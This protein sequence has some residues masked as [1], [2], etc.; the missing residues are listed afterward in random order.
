M[1]PTR[2]P[3]QTVELQKPAG[4]TDE[5][6]SPLPVFRDGTYC[7]S[8]WAPSFGE[9]LRILFGSPIW[10]WIW[11]GNTQPPVSLAIESPFTTGTAAWT[12]GRLCLSTTN[13]PAGAPI[14]DRANSQEK[15]EPF[16]Q[17]RGLAIHLRP[18]RRNRHG[19][20]A[21]G[22]ALFIGVEQ[23]GGHS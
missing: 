11:S 16:R 19:D 10:L 14:V 20:R 21:E 4:M 15:I 7:I 1:K 23:R 8:R 13:Q 12:C 17:W 18:W 3:E 5:K 22:P 2:F 9:R 6:C